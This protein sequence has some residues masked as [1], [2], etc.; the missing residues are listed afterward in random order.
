[1]EVIIT[2]DIPEFVELLKK[3]D[4]EKAFPQTMAAMNSLA[5]MHME[6]WRRYA[7]GTPMPGSPRVVNSR[8][9]YIRSIQV[10]VSKRDEK[11]VFT[12]SP[13]HQYI[14]DGHG[15]IDLKPGLLA[16]KKARYG[17]EGPYNIVAFRHGVPGTLKS[18]KP[19]P[20]NLYEFIKKET[21]KAEAAGQN[22]YSRVTGRDSK[23]APPQNRMYSWGMRVPASKGGTP[24][25]KKTSQGKYT[26]KTGKYSSM[27]RM[28]SKTQKAKHSHYITFRVVSMKSDPASWIV[29]PLAGAPI[30]E[31]VVTTM[32][33]I[34]E[35]M[36]RAALEED[37]KA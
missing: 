5:Y 15:E 31:A 21:D 4:S 1:M 6:T 2:Q 13:T 20:L 28:Q 7:S 24:K 8:G 9:D 14:E 37:L 32:R 35:D 11:L 12:D 29:P 25:T 10:D 19:M 17:K 16:G 3:V 30:R 36:I 22:A 18:N 23:K 34:V 27:V 26:W 33:P